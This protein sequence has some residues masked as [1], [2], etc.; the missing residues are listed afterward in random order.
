[1]RPAAEVGRLTHEVSATDISRL[2]ED[3]MT[4]S[5]TDRQKGVI[6]YI[7]TLIMV[8]AVAAALATEALGLALRPA[9]QPRRRRR[10]SEFRRHVHAQ[11]GPTGGRRR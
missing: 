6:F 11:R 9:G 5:M 7:L 3:R 4:G 2:E 1:M 10:A 8:V